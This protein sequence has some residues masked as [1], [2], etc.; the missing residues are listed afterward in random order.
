M[1][2]YEAEASHLAPPPTADPHQRVSRPDQESAKE[3]MFDMS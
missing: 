1:L 3:P 2:A